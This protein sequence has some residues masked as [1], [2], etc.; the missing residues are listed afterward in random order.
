MNSSS[1]F[2]GLIMLIIMIIYIQYFNKPLCP[3]CPSC[4]NNKYRE[5]I[6]VEETPTAIIASAK[7]PVVDLDYRKMYDPLIEATRRLDRSQ[8]P[9]PYFDQLTNIYT[10]GF[11]D[12]FSLFGLLMRKNQKEHISKEIKRSKKLKKEF[13][14]DDDVI[15]EFKTDIVTINMADDKD[16]ILYLFGRQ[17]YP[18][19]NKYEYYAM[20]TDRTSKVKFTLDLKYDRELFDDD[21]VYIKEVGEP[22]IVS[23]YKQDSLKYNPFNIT[24]I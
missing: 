15:G 7:D 5:K 16:R 21:I 1:F 10:R 6:T 8:I 17:I 18:G 3:V 24:P 4:D 20:T 13:E 2:I 22:Y 9:S 19:S 14:R 12:N 23:L 11:P